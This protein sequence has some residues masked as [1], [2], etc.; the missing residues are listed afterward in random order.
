[1]EMEPFKE[2]SNRDIKEPNKPL[3]SLN[4]CLNKLEATNKEDSFHCLLPLKFPNSL[5]SLS[6]SLNSHRFLR[7]PNNHRRFHK[8]LRLHRSPLVL[9]TRIMAV[10]KS[11]DKN[12]RS[13]PR[14][15]QLNQPTTRIKTI[16]RRP[17]R[18]TINRPEETRN[19]R[20]SRPSP[21]PQLN[22]PTKPQLLKSR[23]IRPLPQLSPR[24]QLSP[25]PQLSPK[26]QPS[27]LIQLPLQPL[28]RLI[29]LQPQLS[30]PLKSRATR[31]LPLKSRATQPLPQLLPLM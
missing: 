23:A 6:P 7:F 2:D 8:S 5:S 18:E 30:L 19:T 25:R 10:S 27:S 4:K 1:M 12:K 24:H 21:R 17:T 11:K 14:R 31:P 29:Q 22:S 20:R 9:T 13:T 16:K 3:S 15:N 26:P 28:R